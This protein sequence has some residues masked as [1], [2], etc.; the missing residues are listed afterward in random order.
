MGGD[1][2]RAADQVVALVGTTGDGKST[3]VKLVARFY[4]PTSGTLRID[5][6]PIEE[7]DLAAYR[8]L[9]FVPQQPFLFA[10]TIRS[11]I[12]YGNPDATDLQVE[13]AARAV[14]AHAFIAE[15]PLGYHT[16]VS[17]QGRSL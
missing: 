8:Q 1:W 10:G 17:E 3:L 6:M 13:R 16:P 15:L 5:G 11:N 7:L 14:G 12:A 2:N 9:G 4:D